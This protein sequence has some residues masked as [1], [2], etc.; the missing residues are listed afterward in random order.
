MELALNL[1]WAVIAAASYAVLILSL[2]RQSS[3]PASRAESGQSR[4]RCV[5][6]LTCILAILFP[7]ISLTDDLHEMQATAE[8]AS[9]SGLIIKKCVASHSP[10]ADRTRHQSQ[11]LTIFAPVPATPRWTIAGQLAQRQTFLTLP[12]FNRSALDRA[13]PSDSMARSI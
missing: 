2:R 13:P 12:S 1:V 11:I 7:V 6:A 4:A 3:G 8:E 10:S 9:P 5:I